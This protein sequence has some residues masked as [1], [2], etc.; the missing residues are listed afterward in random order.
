MDINIIYPQIE[1]E[2]IVIDSF[3]VVNPVTEAGVF[4]GF[5][6]EF[7]DLGEINTINVQE[8]L[9]CYLRKK[10]ENPLTFLCLINEENEFIFQKTSEDVIYDNFHYKYDL[11][12]KPY[13][14]DYIFHIK[15]F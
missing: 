13:Q 14:N 8:R 2:E 11:R 4:F 10:G 6:K 12:I 7:K 5:S 9:N 15:D 1:K 3:D